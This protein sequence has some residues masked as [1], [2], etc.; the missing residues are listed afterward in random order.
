M[1]RRR[2]SAKLC[3]AVNQL[4]RDPE[5]RRRLGD[6]GYEEIARRYDYESLC[7]RYVSL[8]EDL[9]GPGASR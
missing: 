4:A 3:D 5:F 2:G 1:R 8:L 9:T 7:S 6:A